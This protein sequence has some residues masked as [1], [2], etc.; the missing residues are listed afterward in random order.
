MKDKTKSRRT[1][2]RVVAGMKPRGVNR[3]LVVAG[4]DNPTVG[5]HSIPKNL[6]K[7]LAN[8]DGDVGMMS[9]S[10]DDNAQR[11][12]AKIVKRGIGVASVGGFSCELHDKEF[13]PVDMPF[14]ENSHRD[15]SLLFARAIMYEIWCTENSMANT[16]VMPN[17]DAVIEMRRLPEQR[18]ALYEAR[19]L[20][21]DCL[22]T[23]P[24]DGDHECRIV[25]RYKFIKSEHAIIAASAA[26]ARFDRFYDQA[27]RPMGKEEA[28]ADPNTAWT[29][30]VFPVAGGHTVA[31]SRIRDSLSE[32]F[33]RHIIHASGRGLEEA[34]S[35]HLILFSE[36]WIVNPAIW[37]KYGHKRQSAVTEAYNNF[38]ELFAEKYPFN[39]SGP[40]WEEC[41]I[42]NKH[43]INFFRY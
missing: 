5:G 25:H 1:W 40:W 24:E 6:Q 39:G 43:Q 27:G 2:G 22:T 32:R 18:K 29:M 26:S 38:P 28:G 11:P 33:H 17:G 10:F 8:Q 16:K 31:I 3:C 42:S 36:N 15:M 19:K 41:G 23:D 12:Q 7:G 21:L 37:H 34:V 20:V 35:G 30:S 9:V 4:C 14:D 13:N